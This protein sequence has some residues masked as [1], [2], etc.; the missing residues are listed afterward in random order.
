MVAVIGVLDSGDGPNQMDIR[1]IPPRFRGWIKAV[2]DLLFEVATRQPF[3]L[4][5]VRFLNV[6]VGYL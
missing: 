5:R 2:T 6:R 1:F 3:K 4:M